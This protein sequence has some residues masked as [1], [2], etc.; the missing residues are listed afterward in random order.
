MT[1]AAATQ[2]AVRWSSARTCARKAVYEATGAPARETTDRERRIMFRGRRL[3]RDYADM[4]AAEHGENAIVREKQ[5][6]WPLGIGHQDVFV[7][8]T[9]TV[10]EV[11][12]SAHASDAMIDSK[13]LQLVGYVE[14][15][16]EARNGML[17]ILDPSDY[18]EERFF[19]AKDTARYAELVGLMLERIG[20]VQAGLAGDLSARECR[21]PSEAVGRFCRHAEHCFEGWEPPEAPPVD[22]PEVRELAVLLYQ[23]KRAERE[24]IRAK[25]EIETRRREVEQRLA[26][27]LE[28][29]EWQ[30]G[31]LR[32]KRL[33]VR[34]HESFDLRKARLAGV[35]IP[36]EF[37]KLV[38]GYERW[39]CE[40][41]GDEPLLEAEAFGE[42]APW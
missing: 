22:E 28:P 15:D 10:V 8:E 6:V 11:L 21:K 29:G 33:T 30:V 40:R 24:A 7:K 16:P 26:D 36:D 41:T 32:V 14:H 5:V 23:A 1:T 13:L 35:P 39:T 42:V 34:P 2:P 20:Q 25:A 37:V 17:V 18:S 4:L 3:G 9:G 31:P 27:L 38:G 19:V 12:S